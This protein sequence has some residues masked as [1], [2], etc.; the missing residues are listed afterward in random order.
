MSREQT[1]Q[2]PLALT[3]VGLQGIGSNAAPE[4]LQRKFPPDMFTTVVVPV[5][6]CV[7]RDFDV[8][9]APLVAGYGSCTGAPHPS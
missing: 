4:Q 1:V 3:T 2:A 5:V 7:L 9:Y 6:R 8:V